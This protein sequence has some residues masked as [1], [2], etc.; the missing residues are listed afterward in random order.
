V[1]WTDLKPNSEKWPG[2]EEI[3]ILVKMRDGHENRIRS[4]LPKESQTTGPLLTMIH[5]GGF[6]IGR[7]EHEEEGYR[8]WVKSHGGTAVSVGH[9]L[10]PEVKFPVPTEDCYDSLKWVRRLS[11]AG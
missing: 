1:L 2:I 8:K 11:S 9:R 7:L 5:G 3:D 6:C 10:A 4:Y